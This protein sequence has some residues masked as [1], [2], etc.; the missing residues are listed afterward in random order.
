MMCLTTQEDEVKRDTEDP[1]ASRMACLP[2]N[3]RAWRHQNREYGKI[4]DKESQ[5]RSQ[6]PGGEQDDLFTSE[7][8]EPGGV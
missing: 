4:L 8:E 1:R 5:G 2:W 7:Q 6:R 3:R